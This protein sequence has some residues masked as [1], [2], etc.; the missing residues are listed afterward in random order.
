MSKVIT[1]IFII[2]FFMI[3]AA[4]IVI[5]QES[6][7]KEISVLLTY[8]GHDFEQKP[9]F[10]MFDKLAGVKYSC[11]QLPDSANLLNPGL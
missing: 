11:A 10:E 4:P 2:I 9:F 5:G 3:T 1:K 6:G 8:G 7:R